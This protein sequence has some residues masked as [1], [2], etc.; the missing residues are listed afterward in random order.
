MLKLNISGTSTSSLLTYS[1]P[2]K[3]FLNDYVTDIVISS[4]FKMPSVQ[5]TFADLNI[6]GYDNFI[7]GKNLSLQFELIGVNETDLKL[8][9]DITLEQLVGASGNT[10]NIGFSGKSDDLT[11]YLNS[12]SS[13]FSKTLNNFKEYNK[14]QQDLKTESEKPENQGKWYTNVFKSISNIV[15]TTPIKFIP[16]LAA[17]AGFVDGIVGVFGGNME[18]TPTPIPLN[19]R[20]NIQLSGKMTGYNPLAIF[21]LFVPGSSFSSTDSRAPLDNTPLGI[22]NIASKPTLEYCTEIVG[23][24]PNPV[25]EHD[26]ISYYWGTLKLA[27]KDPIQLVLNPSLNVRLVSS[28]L[29]LTSN[30]Y[31]PETKYCDQTIFHNTKFNS[32]TIENTFFR[33]IDIFMQ[34]DIVNRFGEYVPNKITLELKFVS[35]TN[36]LDTVYFLKTYPVNIVYNPGV[37]NKSSIIPPQNMS[38][39]V[40][41]ASDQYYP[42]ISWSANL[43][44]NIS[45]YQIWRRIFNGSNWGGYQLVTTVSNSFTQWVDYG[46][47]GAGS[48]SKIAEYKICA[49]DNQNIESAFTEPKQINWGAFIDL[50]KKVPI[51]KLT[52]DK[53]SLSQNYPNPFNPATQI[54]YTVPEQ[55]LVTIAIFDFLG[56]EIAILENADKPAGKYEIYFD[57]NN[58]ASGLYFYSIKAGK[59]SATHK[60]LLLK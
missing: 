7:S 28:K 6:I 5:W 22:F 20:G 34:G 4:V 43:E 26:N 44:P 37:M 39:G 54:S 53:Y 19:F 13:P 51:V 38:V 17:M 52:P 36:S 40:T 29:S 30:N 11:G 58:L 24:V 10:A 47:W 45:N 27:I 18:Q 8:T 57:A 2:E 16:G 41:F 32:I 14:A 31:G 1:D 15:N 35:N 50:N 46:L 48:G 59:Y 9:G 49:V 60:M 55:S 23:Y 25:G 42:K 56:R 33:N 21:Y 12:L 3:P